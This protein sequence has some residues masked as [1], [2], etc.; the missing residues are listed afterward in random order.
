MRRVGDTRIRYGAGSPKD[1]NFVKP[2]K[3]SPPP[4]SALPAPPPDYEIKPDDLMLI[5]PLPRYNAMLA[6]LCNSLH[7]YAPGF[8][9]HVISISSTR[10]PCVQL[11]DIFEKGSREYM[12]DDSGRERAPVRHSRPAAKGGWSRTVPLFP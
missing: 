5:M 4:K 7:M 9:Y 6:V 10:V 8:S 1:E 2:H 11:Q 3:A 12:L